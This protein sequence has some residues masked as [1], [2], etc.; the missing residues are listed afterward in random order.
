ME[1]IGLCWRWLVDLHREGDEELNNDSTEN[2]DNGDNDNVNITESTDF[3][4][5]VSVIKSE[6]I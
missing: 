3:V 2:V 5:V 1:Q 6:L 4:A